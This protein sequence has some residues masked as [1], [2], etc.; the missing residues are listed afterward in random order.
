MKLKFA[1]AAVVLLLTA[2]PAGAEDKPLAVNYG[3]PTAD[4]VN[5]YVAQD[6]HLFKQ[7]GLEPKFFSFPS[8]APLLAALKSESLD[9]ALAGLGLAFAI[10]QHIP[11]KMLYWVANDSTGE[12]LIVDPKSGIKTYQDIAKAQ[13]IGAASGTC[14]QVALY[15]LA[16]KVGI[17]YRKLNVVNIPAPIFRNSFLSH[18][19][20]AG[21][22][23]TPYSVMLASEGYPV[24]NWDSDY[25]PPGGMCPRTVAVRPAFLKSHPE[26][27]RK[28]LEVEALATEAVTK[29]PHL[30]VEALAKRLGLTEPVAKGSYERT[31]LNR[32]TIAEQLD[33]ASPYSITSDNG[34]ATK[35]F[36]AIEV[37]H[38]TKSVPETV[39]LSAIHDAIDPAYLKEYAAS[40]GKQ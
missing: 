27:G 6:L 35:F 38:R 24:V 23:W 1:H 40:T 39:P 15:M 33:P 3:Y 9:V 8:G 31:Y 28:L 20:D 7:V 34:L 30:A 21:V 22:A 10:G 14:A 13:K 11:L 32:P 5:L 2:V 16:E 17:D 36:Q 25:T 4:H 37:L 19:I 12:G 26:I 18:S 29:N